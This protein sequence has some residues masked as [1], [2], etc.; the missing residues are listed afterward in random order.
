VLATIVSSPLLGVIARAHGALYEET[1]TGFKWIANRALELERQTGATFV[2][3]YEEAL[4]Y[5][6]GTA[7]RDKD[8]VSAALAIADLA[9]WC[10]AQGTT[11][12]GQLAAIQR[13]YG[14]Y[15]SAQ[16]FVSVGDGAS[17]DGAALMAR[18]RSRLPQRLA[19]IPVRSVK[20]YGRGVVHSPAGE[21]RSGLPLAD[22]LALELA[23]GARVSIRPSGTEAKVKVYFDL[24]ESIAPGE[25]L[26]VV[27]ERGEAR[28]SALAAAV[29]ADVIGSNSAEP[30]SDS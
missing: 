8:G 19:D 30:A 3:G 15:L 24:A 13:E 11:L 25:A 20:D 26:T 27:R 22:V 28:L 18:I 14:F 1:L 2:F 21:Q 10:R 16:R 7:V 29:L 17:I 9:G 23:D 4:G 12:I 6:I 5:S